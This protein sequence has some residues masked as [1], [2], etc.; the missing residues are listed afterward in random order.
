[1]RYVVS[2]RVRLCVRECVSV[3]TEV[4]DDLQIAFSPCIRL[5]TPQANLTISIHNICRIKARGDFM[6]SVSRSET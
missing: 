1:M 2:P 6:C 3:W 4:P 5:E